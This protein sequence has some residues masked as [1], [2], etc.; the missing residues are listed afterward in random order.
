MH[1]LQFFCFL[2]QKRLY[3]L[4]TAMGMAFQTLRQ[5]MNGKS[6]LREEEL[7]RAARYLEV[8]RHWLEMSPEALTSF[9]C[10]MFDLK[11]VPV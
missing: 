1:P 8:P 5:K 9:L 10:E 11:S 3:D 6:P 7:E 4:A 2:R